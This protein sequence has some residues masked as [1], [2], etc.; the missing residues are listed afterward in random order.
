M[1]EKVFKYI[2][3][4]KTLDHLSMTMKNAGKDIGYF[5]IILGIIFMAY[6]ILGHLV[7]G[8]MIIDYQEFF[9]TW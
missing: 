7:F 6:A 3:L 4:N 2:S 9:K 5:V 1:N 8:E